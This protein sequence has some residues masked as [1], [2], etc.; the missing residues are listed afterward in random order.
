M[1]YGIFL[2]FAIHRLWN[3]EKVLLKNLNLHCASDAIW[4]ISQLFCNEIFRIFRILKTSVASK[5]HIFLNPFLKP[6][7]AI[8]QLI[9]DIGLQRLNI[10][11]HHGDADNGRRNRHCAE[12]HS[13]KR[14]RA[15]RSW[16]FPG[17]R[18]VGELLVLSHLAATVMVNFLGRKT[19]CGI[20]FLS[21]APLLCWTFTPLNNFRLKMAKMF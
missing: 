2:F 18:V 11:K 7:L 20:F 1:E 10:M 15:Q 16:P 6:Y 13:T 9:L 17:F 14:N 4:I 21:Q 8:V 12:N 5:S 3:S 19:K